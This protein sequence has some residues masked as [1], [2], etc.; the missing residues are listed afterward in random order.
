MANFASLN[1]SIRSYKEDKR[2]RNEQQAL[3]L[4]SR[5]IDIGGENFWEDLL[6]IIGDGRG[7]AAILEIN[8]QKVATWRSKIQKHL[9]KYHLTKDE[10]FEGRSKKRRIV[11]PDDH[12]ED[13]E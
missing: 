7:F 5:G 2:N 3:D 1:E 9:D 13:T 8:Q 6:R 10:E 4:I 11:T 12:W